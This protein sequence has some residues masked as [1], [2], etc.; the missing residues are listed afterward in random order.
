MCL[1]CEQ[2][3][4]SPSAL[5][6]NRNISSQIQFFRRVRQV[7]KSDNYIRRVSQSFRLATC[8]ISAPTER[9]IMKFHILVCLRKSVQ[10]IP[11][12]LKSN[13]NNRH[14]TYRPIYICDH[15]SLSSAWNEKCFRQ[16]LCRKS[17]HTFCAQWLFLRKQCHLWDNVSAT[18]SHVGSHATNT[19]ALHHALFEKSL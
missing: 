10:R 14:F 7:A 5:H 9:I 11:A 13:N 4:G 12:T 6:T 1:F 15:N 2:Q 19:T 18:L 17:K 3:T 8:N 16:K